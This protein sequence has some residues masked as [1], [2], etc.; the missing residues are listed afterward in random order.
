M[1]S[2]GIKQPIHSTYYMACTVANLSWKDH[3]EFHYTKFTIHGV[4]LVTPVVIIFHPKILRQHAKAKM[5]KNLGQVLIL[6]M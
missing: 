3:S 5:V 1:R 4:Q 6:M 2:V